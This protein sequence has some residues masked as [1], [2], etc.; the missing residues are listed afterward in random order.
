MKHRRHLFYCIFFCSVIA[1][2]GFFLGGCTS[3]GKS[4]PP[5]FDTTVT[6][7]DNSIPGSFS[8]Q[9][10]LHTDS[11]AIDLFFQNFPAFTPYAEDV[12]LFYRERDYACAWFDSAGLIEQAHNL[13]N[14]I[15]NV[16]DEGLTK[17]LPYTNLL[18]SL[19]DAAALPAQGPADM[20]LELMLTASYFAFAHNVW[21]GMDDTASLAVQ[22]FLPRKKVSY[23]D[24]LDSLLQGNG[25]ERREPVYRQY[26]LLRTFLKQYR[27]LS[28][29]EWPQ[30]VSD[31]KSFKPGDSSPLIAAISKRLYLLGDYA[32]DTT[33][34][35]YGDSLV[36][37]VK[38]F[39][40]R[41]GLAEDGVMGPAF[42]AELN[43][44]PAERIT[45]ILVNMER[46]RWVP[47]QLLSDYLV[48]NI[49]E[50]RLH[51]YQ[52]DSLAWSCNVV[53][54]KQVHKT[55]VFTGQIKYVVFSPYWN[56]P[57][58]IVRNEILP[59]MKRDK[60][61]LARH[62]ME[63]TG[64]SGGLPVVRQRPGPTNSLGLVKFLFP[65]SYNIYLHDSPA[66]SLF[67]ES[68]RAYSHGCIRVAEPERLAN[69]LLRNDSTWTPEKINA[70][71]HAG[72]EKYV[73]LR[74]PVPVF[75]AYFTA[76]VDRSGRI[77]FRKDIYNR[78]PRMAEML[79]EG[80]D[81]IP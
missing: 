63:I 64:N 44:P 17:P 74:E 55:M 77:N 22:W 34:E 11:I 25:T 65:N 2:H 35:H 73:T 57:P 27:A 7:W 60:N 21:Q 36:M 48:V 52:G 23:R 69:F 37:A 53:V 1:S 39:Q 20:H 42:M 61:Y 68:S 33:G 8:T 45:Q 29:I 31:R 54:G 66:K 10:E 4:A 5:H 19:L 78:D 26:G 3:G 12:W 14:R 38:T 79:L 70:A 6:V 80:T 13:V 30:L 81:F 9:T 58:S 72:N 50:F 71:M 24:Y 41:H 76:F 49:P 59:G 32:G 28:E 67:G 47:V 43:V 46:S 40:Q 51:V 15:R 75:I 16:N 56:V 62:N 18:D